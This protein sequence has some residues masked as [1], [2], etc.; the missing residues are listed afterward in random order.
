VQYRQMR[1][2][3]V[4]TTGALPPKTIGSCVASSGNCVGL[5]KPC[6]FADSTRFIA[7]DTDLSLASAVALPREHFSTDSAAFAFVTVASSSP[8]IAT[9]FA[10][11]KTT[12]NSAVEESEAVE[13]VVSLR[14]AIVTGSYRRVLVLLTY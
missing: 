5:W 11:P 4:V 8:I 12:L 3:Q 9:A 2:E 10:L 14:V 1:P 7:V 13:T 6:Y